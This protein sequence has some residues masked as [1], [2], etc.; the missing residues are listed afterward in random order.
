[1]LDQLVEQRPNPL[2]GT[3]G[4]GYCA[5]VLFCWGQFSLYERP[6]VIHPKTAF[7]PLRQLIF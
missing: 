4:K 5:G 1:M 7:G 3:L 6:K 2:T